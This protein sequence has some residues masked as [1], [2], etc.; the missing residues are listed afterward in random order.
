SQ[1]KAAARNLEFERAALLRDQV[2]ELRRELVGD[3]P[4]AL[5]RFIGDSVPASSSPSAVP[6]RSGGR[7]RNGRGTRRPRR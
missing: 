4:D 1:M 7:M 2:V 3:T 5:G 6:T